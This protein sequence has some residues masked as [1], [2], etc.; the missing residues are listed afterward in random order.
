MCQEHWPATEPS[1]EEHSLLLGEDARSQDSIA[2]LCIREQGGGGFSIYVM[3]ELL[4]FRAKREE[5]SRRDTDK[6]RRW[7]N[8]RGRERYEWG[9][10]TTTHTH[11]YVHNKQ[12]LPSPTACT[13]PPWGNN[14]NWRGFRFIQNAIGPNSNERRAAENK[15]VGRSPMEERPFSHNAALSPRDIEPRSY[16]SISAIC[17]QQNDTVWH[18]SDEGAAVVKLKQPEWILVS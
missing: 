17:A 13:S 11:A 6:W 4:R 1:H 9:S 8:T 10:V 2:A 18:G 16:L 3:E 15:V 12:W 5:Q 14:G 7:G